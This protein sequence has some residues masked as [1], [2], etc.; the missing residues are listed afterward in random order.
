VLFFLFHQVIDP[1]GRILADLG[2]GTES[3][4]SVVE[5]DPKTLT[6]VRRG[7]PVIDHRNP[8]VY[9]EITEV[10]RI[11][12]DGVMYNFGPNDLPSSTIFLITDHSMA[13]VNKKCVLPGR[14]FG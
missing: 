14:K 2:R 11:P 7:M 13:F 5:I 8:A 4:Y 12:K 9:D 1:W 6:D 3:T 10:L